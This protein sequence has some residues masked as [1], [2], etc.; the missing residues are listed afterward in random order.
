MF[1]TAARIVIAVWL[2]ATGRAALAEN[3]VALVIGNSNYTLAPLDNPKNDAGDPGRKR[4][5]Q[6]I[7]EWTKMPPFALH[8][9]KPLS[10]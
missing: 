2:I 6:P 5:R 8:I 4:K 10:S 3:R 9:Q 1:R 7:Q